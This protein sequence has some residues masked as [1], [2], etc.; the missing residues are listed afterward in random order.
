MEIDLYSFQGFLKNERKARSCWRKILTQES[1][2]SILVVAHNAANQALV[3][4]TI[5]LGTEYFRILL[6]SNCGVSVLDFTPNLEGGSP[7]IC[8]NRLNLE[9]KPVCGLYLSLTDSL[10]T[11][12]R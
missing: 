7:L 9:G 4:T 3:A 2:R 8:L 12:C 6:Q 1:R 11:L 10:R 5:G